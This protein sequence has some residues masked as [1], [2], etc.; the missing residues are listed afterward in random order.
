MAIE[1]TSARVSLREK[2][3][4][5]GGQPAENGRPPPKFADPN[6]PDVVEHS[7]D[8][9]HEALF[10][11][12]TAVAESHKAIILGQHAMAMEDR[13][14]AKTRLMDASK[15]HKHAARQIVR[16]ADQLSGEE[17]RSRASAT[18][19][20]LAVAHRD[21]ASR[22]EDAAL[23][24][25]LI[26]ARKAVDHT[27]KQAS[28]LSSLLGGVRRPDD[29]GHTARI[30]RTSDGQFRLHV[31]QGDQQV[32]ESE[33][34]TKAEAVAAAV[35]QHADMDWK[36]SDLVGINDE[37]NP[38]AGHELVRASVTQL[39][40]DLD[41][42]IDHNNW[43]KWDAEHQGMFRRGFG[44]EL[45]GEAKHTGDHGRRIGL[46]NAATAIEGGAEPRH[47]HRM[48]DMTQGSHSAVLRQVAERFAHNREVAASAKG[49][50]TPV[51]PHDH[52]NGKYHLQDMAV[53]RAATSAASK[54][55]PGQV[56]HGRGEMTD[57][58]YRAHRNHVEYELA[59][60][61][62]GDL[63]RSPWS[64]HNRED[65]VNG[66]PGV[67]TEERQRLHDQILRE[68]DK[69]AETVPREH[70]A[71]IM[72]GLGGS[73]KSTLLRH[74]AQSP[75]SVA[76][77]L[78]IKFDRYDRK[79]TGS[80][81]TGG[82][83]PS[84]FVVINPDDIKERMAEL[85]AVP[86]VDELSPM[87]ATVFAH[88]E[89]SMLAK[90]VAQRLQGQGTNVIHD[91]TLNSVKSGQERILGD[92]K[93]NLKGLREQGYHTAGVM[94]DVTPEQSVRNAENRHRAGEDRF[95]KSIGYGGRYVPSDLTRAQADATGKY[96]SKNRAAFEELKRQGLFD[97]TL[98]IDNEN[99]ANRLLEETGQR[100]GTMPFVRDT[101]PNPSPITGAMEAYSRG[102]MDFPALTAIIAH[103]QF[104]NPATH[105]T[106]N[107]NY[108]DV[109]DTTYPEAGTWSEV[110]QGADTGLITDDE[111]RQITEAMH[112][113]RTAYAQRNID[114]GHLEVRDW[115]EWDAEREAHEVRDAVGWHDQAQ[116]ASRYLL[117]HGGSTA[118]RREVARAHDNA[119][120]AF[121]QIKKHSYNPDI[122]MAAD[123]AMRAHMNAS[124]TFQQNRTTRSVDETAHKNADAA[125]RRLVE[126]AKRGGSGKGAAAR[127][128]PMRR[129][130]DAVIEPITSG[131][132]KGQVSLKITKDGKF[133]SATV[134]PSHEAAMAAAKK[135]GAQVVNSIPAGREKRRRIEAQRIG[136]P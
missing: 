58:E 53:A 117:D 84:N 133:V 29:V 35:A 12:D 115:A 61:A 74:E 102:E 23:G 105:S 28:F 94:V 134:H 5:P 121:R 132:Q 122:R 113:V 63:L 112:E 64:T 15:G 66:V 7:T 52:A 50:A 87:E 91:I 39:R 103:Y 111:L 8:A 44:R 32:A 4:P 75:D 31:Y 127:P 20:R 18:A 88:E 120:F 107:A 90:R 2:P 24:G 60:H 47:L 34:P 100:E 110:V 33:H 69:L 36:N 45:R 126:L 41:L 73:G 25:S 92:Q 118:E 85:G 55:N 124:R 119:A 43:A 51:I 70:R 96:R 17:R 116:K 27:E 106:P 135:K 11:H 54:L 79:G 46:Q 56:H 109:E 83:K 136:E 72:G 6:Q 123:R 10:K 22:L 77:R 13:R 104:G 59:R 99:F 62:S 128:N 81:K 42:D 108:Y 9:A 19:R 80:D 82:D 98:L 37:G 78:G 114:P 57:A 40:V 65:R 89:A 131:V 130:K 30:T 129:A 14:A 49:A 93:N 3:A 68:Y 26:K 1:A 48:A 97:H 38:V 101:V 67:Y 71:I 95:N 21:A 125:A 76:G 16:L 86:E